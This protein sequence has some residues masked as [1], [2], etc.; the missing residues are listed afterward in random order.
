MFLSGRALEVSRYLDSRFTAEFGREDSGSDGA[1]VRGRSPIAKKAESRSFLPFEFWRKGRDSNPRYE[2]SVCRLSRAVHST[3]LP[4]FHRCSANMPAVVIGFVDTSNLLRRRSM[5][6]FFEKVKKRLKKTADGMR[7]VPGRR[8]THEKRQ[9]AEASC[10][11]ES[12]RKGRDSNPRYGISVC[13]LSRAVHSTTL[14][15]FQDGAS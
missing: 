1:G 5:P 8:R 13:R 4:P 15:P 2:I 3:T 6:E 10:L 9:E 7:D 12:W 14:P 11:S